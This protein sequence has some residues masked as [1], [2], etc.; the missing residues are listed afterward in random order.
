VHKRP[1]IAV[2]LSA[3]GYGHCT[4]TAALC[5]ELASRLD[6]EFH[7]RASTPRFLWPQQLAGST[8]TWDERPCDVGVVQSDDLTVDLGATRGAID[9]W[10]EAVPDRLEEEVQWLRSEA[11]DLLLG[12]VPPMAFVAA[13][14]AGVPSVAVANFSWDWIYEGMGFETAAREAADA[15]AV[16]G[17]LIELT[18]A[19]PMPAFPRRLTVGMIG[20]RSSRDGRE[21]RR[22]L[23]VTDGEQL[24]L[25]AFRSRAGDFLSLPAPRPGIRYVQ[26]SAVGSS[27]TR[28][29]RSD[30]VTLG[31]DVDFVDAVAAAD[32]IV[33]KPGYGIIGDSMRAGVRLLYTER[34]G[35]PE[36]PVL[37]A[38]L[39]AQPGT[40]PISPERLA[41]GDWRDEL[42]CL[43]ASPRPQPVGDAPLQAA[44]EAIEGALTGAA[45]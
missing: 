28:G 42:E 23:G 8:V 35:F 25:P 27:D 4:R 7:L 20:R 2:Y 14:N 22:C 38:W 32:V 45:R 12:D 21:V 36:D 41:A 43:L 40:A 44:G 1:R 6:P 19:A 37:R 10:R 3:H 30:L 31:P 18:P 39:E 17:L 33:A 9:R 24:I 16:A 5:L 34:S 13:A 29:A 11:V 26:P 15:Y